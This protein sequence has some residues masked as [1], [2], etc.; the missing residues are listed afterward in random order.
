MKFQENIPLSQYSNYLIG[1]PARFFFEAKNADEVRWAAKEAR[2]QDLKV[3]VLGGGTNVLI[4]ENGFDGLVLKPNISFIERSGSNLRVGAGTLVAELLDY[5]IAEGL[6]G[7]EWAGGL[8]GTLGGAIRGN[9]GCFGGEI[10]DVVSEVES[11]DIAT[12][13]VLRRMNPEC[14]FSYRSSIFKECDADIGVV[15]VDSQG[16]NVGSSG[17]NAGLLNRVAS[18]REIILA[19]TLAL[20][21]GDPK[22]IRRAIEEKIEYRKNRHPL[23]YPNV[24]SIFK[25]VPVTQIDA[26]IM[27]IDANYIRVHPR[28]KPRRSA[29]TAPVKIDPFPVVPAAYLISEAGLKGVSFGGAMISPKHPNFIVNALG[30]KAEEVLALIQLVKSDVKYKFGIELE[31]EIQI[32]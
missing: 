26:D 13:K 31:E 29:F 9:A 27:Q 10:K 22:A 23:E 25:N 3:F 12:G 2:R 28:G 7:L 16:Q 1:G 8:P 4:G 19:A 30:A 21:P 14:K 11:F 20:R 15:R 32:V 18:G 17:N 6:S 24:G 5:A